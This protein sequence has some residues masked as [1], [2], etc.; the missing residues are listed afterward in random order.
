[1]DYGNII[2]SSNMTSAQNNKVQTI[3]TLPHACG[4]S[5]SADICVVLNT[6][7]SIHELKTILAETSSPQLQF[8]WPDAWPMVR[9]L[10]MGLRAQLGENSAEITQWQQGQIANDLLN[11]SA[12]LATGK[13]A[14]DQRA[15]FTNQL[16]RAACALGLEPLASPGEQLMAAFAALDALLPDLSAEFPADPL[17]CLP[18]LLAVYEEIDT[19]ILVLDN[20]TA[21]NDIDWAAVRSHFRQFP[22]LLLTTRKQL[23]LLAYTELSVAFGI[24]RYRQQWGLDLT[25]MLEVPLRAYLLNASQTIIEIYTRSLPRGVRD[26]AES[27]YGKLIHDIQNQLLKAQFQYELLNMIFDISEQSAPRLHAE[28]SLPFRKRIDAL[29]NHLQE[30]VALYTALLDANQ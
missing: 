28:R 19:A 27:N 13:V 16:N 23:H 9:Q 12:L 7:A 4:D 8:A 22:N 2:G 17:A 18:Q 14:T 5:R 1:M 6:N 24:G 29:V 20:A 15:T 3:H 11:A 21:L 26:S 30:W 10:S 25:G